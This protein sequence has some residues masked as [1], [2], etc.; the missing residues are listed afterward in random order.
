MNNRMSW[1]RFFVIL[2]VLLVVQF[3]VE[4]ASNKPTFVEVWCGGDD[5][6]TIRLRDV[7]ENVFEASSDFVLSWGNKP[8]TLIVTI[9][10]HVGWKEDGKRTRVFYNVVFTT[11]DDRPLG[12]YK[13]SCWDDAMKK[14]AYK[15]VKDAKVAARKIHRD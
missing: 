10:T 7:L 6:L 3:K 9:P 1:N 2:A 13:G 4:A 5:G 11:V 15:I 14:C 12:S 8:G